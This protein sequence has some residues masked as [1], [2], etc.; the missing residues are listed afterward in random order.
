[1]NLLMMFLFSSLHGIVSALPE[2][3]TQD[4]EDVV[5]VDPAKYTIPAEDVQLLLNNTDPN[6]NYVPSGE[7]QALELVPGTTFSFDNSTLQKRNGNQQF[8]AY[9]SYNCADRTAIAAVQNFGC[10]VCVAWTG[11]N[12]DGALSALLSMHTAFN[13][14]PTASLFAGSTCRGAVH[15]SIGIRH[16]HTSSCT[17]SQFITPT[18]NSDF[19]SAI[20]YYNC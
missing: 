3:P 9:G 15:Q 11:C 8:Q 5:F 19:F 2:P 10:G 1:M 4:N 16:A 17:N 6:F 7:F 20:L 18:G 13:P 14:K 12:C